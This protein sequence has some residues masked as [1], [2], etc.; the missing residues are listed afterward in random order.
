MTPN[1]AENGLAEGAFAPLESVA[2]SRDDDAGEGA[3]TGRVPLECPDKLPRAAVE[4]LV[5]A[6]DDGRDRHADHSERGPASVRPVV[7]EYVFGLTRAVQAEV[8]PG[9]PEAPGARDERLGIPARDPLRERDPTSK[10]AAADSPRLCC[11]VG[12]GPEQDQ[13][14]HAAVAGAG[15]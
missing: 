15:G 9:A 14:H 6:A 8:T 5:P 2:R 7:G 13:P 4:V 1:E 3:G 10:L 11:D 12:D